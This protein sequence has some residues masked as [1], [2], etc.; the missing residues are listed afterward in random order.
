VQASRYHPVT[1][2]PRAR[3]VGRVTLGL[4]IDG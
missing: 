4:D 1:D 2:K 3:L